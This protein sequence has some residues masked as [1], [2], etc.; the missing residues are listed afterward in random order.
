LWRDFELS[1]MI[2]DELKEDLKDNVVNA[3]FG[4][5]WTVIEIDTGQAVPTTATSTGDDR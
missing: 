5:G 1:I 4:R 3:K 2:H